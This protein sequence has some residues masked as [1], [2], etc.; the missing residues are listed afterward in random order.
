M[1]G[2]NIL[3]LLLFCLT[4]ISRSNCQSDQSVFIKGGIL[5][6]K[7]QET[8]VNINPP[9]ALFT[10]YL[11]FSTFENTIVQAKIFE[12][13]YENFCE[14]LNGKILDKIKSDIKTRYQISNRYYS[15]DRAKGYCVGINTR[16]P[17][18]RDNAD[19]RELTRFAEDNDITHIVSGVTPDPRGKVFIFSSTGQQINSEKPMFPQLYYLDTNLKPCPKASPYAWGDLKCINKSIEGIGLAYVKGMSNNLWDLVVLDDSFKLTTTKVICER[20]PNTNTESI[21]GDM[22][23]RMAAHACQ[24]DL[25]NVVQTS[26]LIT[27]EATRFTDISLDRIEEKVNNLTL[28]YRREISPSYE[29]FGDTLM[30]PKL[31]CKSFTHENYTTTSD[32][33]EILLGQLVNLS[34]ALSQEYQIP[35]ALIASYISYELLETV[36]IVNFD[37]FSLICNDNKFL[38]NLNSFD[39][40]DDISR[41]IEFLKLTNDDCKRWYE[42]AQSNDLIKILEK[43]DEF[44]HKTIPIIHSFVNLNF[45]LNLSPNGKNLTSF[46]IDAQKFIDLYVSTLQDIKFFNTTTDTFTDVYFNFLTKKFSQSVSKDIINSIISYKYKRNKR[47]AMLP[48]MLGGLTSS[49]AL[50]DISD[51][52]AALSF[53]GSGISALT[54]L[55]HRDDLKP[56]LDLLKNHSVAIQSLAINQDELQYAYTSMAETISI[57]DDFAR[58]SEFSTA[59]MFQQLD[60]KLA[61]QNI[62]GVI[63]STILKTASVMTNANMHKAS[64]YLLSKKELKD[65]ATDFRNRLIPLSDNLNDIYTQTYYTNKSITYS[66]RIPIIKQENLFNVYRASPIPIFKDGKVFKVDLDAKYIAHSAASRSYSILSDSEYDLCTQSKYC[67][68]TDVLRPI[69]QDTSHCVINSLDQDKQ[70]CPMNSIDNKEP[71]YYVFSNNLIYSVE[72]QKLINLIC[73]TRTGFNKTQITLEGFGTAKIAPGCKVIF[74]NSYEIT[75]HPE[76]KATNLGEVK[77]MEIHK[78]VPSEND[79]NLIIE[80]TKP[81]INIYTPK[82]DEVDT[83]F[84][85]QILDEIVNPVQ[86]LPE[87]FRVLIAITCVIII[88]IILCMCFPKLALW[89]KTCIF[90]KNPKV[91]WT[92]VKNYDGDF[93]KLPREV[94]IQLKKRFQDFVH[95][96]SRPSIL[97][98]SRERVNDQSVENAQNSVLNS[99]LKRQNSDINPSNTKKVR[100]SDMDEHNFP[101]QQQ[102]KVYPTFSF[103]SHNPN[104][105]E[106]TAPYEDQFLG[107]ARETIVLNQP[108]QRY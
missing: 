84:F 53:I 58:K 97:F 78:Y 7:C 20:I 69:N 35:D 24:R 61:L 85:N 64:P 52:R 21:Q 108:M 16:L 86:V 15:L 39:Y 40:T 101:E 59:T 62:V 54:G 102:E 45:K 63:Q 92:T 83:N 65:L 46:K 27:D 18:I 105:Y 43:H 13:S 76:A 44:F 88:F 74:P 89:F 17:E 50:N 57:M 94:S 8:P 93:N 79:Y 67:R 95:N 90:W 9:T 75:I 96:N 99:S 22:V 68:T 41:L 72:G 66:L 51:G 81:P 11:D 37:N 80:V 106:G 36:N 32:N 4:F 91:W 26:K 10:R 48:L 34:K 47:F 29:N 1:A 55:V 71:F 2:E 38:E 73:E 25:V 82:L 14:G 5:Y 33:F 98:G 12:K 104:N 107:N 23:L 70:L 42:Q 49:L 103:T 31:F 56:H 6:E 100:F 30:D 28:R 87:V 19:L 60:H 77:F 3:Y